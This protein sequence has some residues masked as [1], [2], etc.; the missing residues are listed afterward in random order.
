MMHLISKFSVSMGQAFGENLIAGGDSSPRAMLVGMLL[1]A[2]YGTQGL[3]SYVRDMKEYQTIVDL[4]EK[5]RSM[6][7]DWWE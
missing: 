1:G 4:V 7:P 3:P 6:N 5:S 2:E